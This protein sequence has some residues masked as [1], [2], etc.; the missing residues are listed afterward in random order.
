MRCT[1]CGTES[2]TSRKFCAAC[3]SPLSNRCSK[4]GGDNAPSSAFCEDCGT[5]LAGIAAPATTGS[6]ARLTAREIRVTPEQPDTSS[7]IEG[8]RR[9]LTVMFC[10]LVNSTMLSER[11]DPEELRDLIQAYQR[12]CVAAITSFDGYV[13]KYLG[14]GLLVY[15]GYP[16]A[17]EDDAA[18]AVRAGLAII[19]KLRETQLA[20]PLHIRVGIHTGLVVAGEMGSGEYREHLAIVGETPNV[21]AR[22]QEQAP[23]DCVVISA[24]T[25]HL[26]PGLFEIEDMGKRMLKGISSPVSVY[27]VVR[28]SEAQ[29]RFEVALRA[30]LTPLVGREHELGLLQD[31]WEKARQGQ[32]QIVLLSGEAG[33][34]KSR[35]VQ[36]LEN[37]VNIEGGRGIQFRCSAYHQSSAFYPIIDHLQRFLE[38]R[39]EEPAEAKLDKLARMLSRYRFPQPDTLPLLASL[40]SLPQPANASPITLSPRKQKE[41]TQAALIAWTAE[42]AEKAAVYYVWEDLHWADPSSLEALAL[43]VD[44][45]PTTRLLALL[46]FRPDFRPSWPPRSHVAQLVLT[47]LG[48]QQVETMVERI[49]GGK[50]LPA[51]LMREVISKTDGVPLFVEELTKMVMESGLLREQEGRY[52]LTSPLHSLAIPSSLND[53]LMA[54]LDRLGSIKEVAQLGAVVG[55]EFSYELLQAVSSIDEA[56]LQR[57]LDKL[58]ESEILHQRGVLPQAQ[59]FFRHALIHDAAYQSLL[60]STRQQYHK[61]L[62]ETLAE[63]FPETKES[64]P[65]L[66][67]RHYTDAGLIEPAIPYWLQAGQQASRRSAHVEAIRQL[68]TGLELLATLPDTPERAE[69][70][71][72][73]QVTMGTSLLATKGFA[74]PELGK[75]YARARELCR[76]L[77]ETPQLFPVLM[78]LRGFYSV[79][80]DLQTAREIAEELL[81]LAEG[82]NDKTLL[83]E[84]HYALGIPLNLLGEFVQAR[85]HLEQ[86]IALDDP[87]QHRARHFTYGMDPGVTSR[88]LLAW[89]LWFLGYSD[90]SVRKSREA[91]SLARAVA[92]PFSLAYAL[93]LTGFLHQFRREAQP[94]LEMAEEVIALSNEQGFSFWLAEGI[95]LRGWAL[96]AQ[97][98]EEKGIAQILQGLADWR[99]TGARAYGTQFLA[100]LAEVYGIRGQINEGM[101]LLTE[102]LATAENSGE[103]YFEAELYRLRGELLFLQD[104]SKAGEAEPSFRTAIDVARAQSAKFWELRATMSLVR[105]LRDTGRRDEARTMLA[106]I[107]GWFTEGFDTADLKDAKALLDGLNE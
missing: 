94:V 65:E 33:I 98:E 49:T 30:G 90:Q 74:A 79:L 38:F 63:R 20:Q 69:H 42:E 28:G 82:V 57:A 78:G 39:R 46:T 6:S 4:C 71:L 75:A 37:R 35:L 44:Q 102:A 68:T 32:G 95:F 45:V 56:N 50:Q 10:D 80:G 58:V 67:A 13:A 100:I 14:D 21:A 5:A 104:I 18:R 12:A 86:S 9:Q 3:G 7:T 106:E 26:V 62:A 99:A 77:G 47:R 105:L 55:R 53:S 23:P 15:F 40:L 16:T 73:L 92:H 70:E 64:Q 54:R 72:M 36:T 103:R 29:T 89:V 51:E 8:E 27:R 93:T 66:L 43:L 2:T 17:H 81:R 60:K 52:E 1:S 84:A 24:T 31:R 19:D 96:T 22:L 97:G 91:L 101:N 107:Y 88:T 11:L 83:L 61:H 48:R 34:G 59:Y 41:R 25:Y 87:E 85:T 76:Q